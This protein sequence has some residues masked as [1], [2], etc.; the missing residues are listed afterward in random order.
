LAREWHEHG[1]ARFAT[2][3]AGQEMGS[4]K[5]HIQ[6]ASRGRYDKNRVIMLGDALGDLRAAK[7]NQVLFFPIN[8]GLEEE[9]WE[10]F[11]IEASDLFR[12]GEYAAEYERRRIAEFESRLP[13][14]PPWK[15]LQKP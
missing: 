8:P 15:L 6:L 2:V 7:D 9:S 13:D 10:R 3:I 5:E 1:L 12:R 4:K 14:V 11:T